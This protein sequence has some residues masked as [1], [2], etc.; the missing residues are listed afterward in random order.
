MF[1]N[2]YNGRKVLVT[3]HTGFKGSW[4]SIW[5]KLLGA[6][7][8]GF[9]LK[10]IYSPNNY[11]LSNISEKIESEKISD[12]RN[13][14]VLNKFILNVKPDIVFHL[15]AQPLVI[16]SYNNPRLTYE[17][18][19]NGLINLLE[20][21][22]KTNFVKNIVIITSDKC[23]EDLGKDISYK[24]SDKLGGKD[25]YSSS[26]ACAEIITKAYFNSFFK[27]KNVFVSTV[28]AGNVIGGGD[29]SDYRIVPDCIRSIFEK[30][31]LVIRNPN[32]FRPWQHV[33]EPLSGYLLL[34]S[35]L[36]KNKILNG[37]SWNFGPKTNI[38]LNVLDLVNNLYD[39]L[40]TGRIKINTT[41]EKYYESKY[42]NLNI[43]KA[44]K[45]LNWKPIW[46]IN[47]TIKKTAEWY[48][49]YYV[50]KGNMFNFCIKQIKEYILDA[51]S[52]G[53]NWT[54]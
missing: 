50:N 5:L 42:L 28:R 27:H 33:L 21:L 52:K 22:R 18:N 43:S 38:K 7:V 30:K 4:L 36:P 10:P 6:K 45:F 49:E 41:L 16:S 37:E 1:N 19:I 48:R 24:E 51:K 29:W 34:A 14:E 2:Y 32:F 25:P 23:Y 15:A 13:Y 17:V 46:G 35:M 11:T 3:G 9:S 8:Y 26:K 39:E 20:I 54:K 40:G 53:S 44:S 31:L 47:I 12:I